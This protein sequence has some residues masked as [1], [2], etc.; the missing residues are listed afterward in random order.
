MCFH[1]M[2]VYAGKK[3]S[4]YSKKL[5]EMF[6][7][8]YYANRHIHAMLNVTLS[9][10]CYI[11]SCYISVLPLTLLILCLNINTNGGYLVSRAESSPLPEI[12]VSVKNNNN[13]NNNNNMFYCFQHK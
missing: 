12:G 1:K 10:G 9:I 2:Y 5:V 7:L 8:G 4:P 11:V 3:A 13:N 6:I